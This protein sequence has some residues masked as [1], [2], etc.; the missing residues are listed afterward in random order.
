[1]RTSLAVATAGLA[2]LVSGCGAPVLPAGPEVT[3]T[4]DVPDGVTGVRVEGRGTVELTEG[5]P[6]LEV[7]AGADLLSDVR[8]R[9]VG[10]TLVLSLDSGWPFGRRGDVLYRLSLPS[11]DTVSVT[12]SGDVRA[13]GGAAE[14]PRMSVTGS[15]TLVARD[16]AVATVEVDVSGSGEVRLSGTTDALDVEV[17][18]SGDVDAGQLEAADVTV[19]VSGS[20]AVGVTATDSIE[21]QVSGSGDVVYGGDPRDVRTDT[22]GSGEIRRR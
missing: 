17:S 13:D 3:E 2:L 11:W 1:M 5:A 16:L 12:G 10:T 20:G 7:T 22:S 21:A 6:S 15:G 4:R 9:A 19:S 18:G 14:D 8:V